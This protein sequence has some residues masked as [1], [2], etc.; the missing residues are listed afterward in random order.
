MNKFLSDIDISM[1]GFLCKFV[2]FWFTVWKA[3]LQNIV[4]ILK[5][6]LFFFLKL[7]IEDFECHNQKIELN[8]ARDSSFDYCKNIEKRV[9]PT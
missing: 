5:C 2:R 4:R 3:S 1:K 6:E 8:T 9:R 7:L